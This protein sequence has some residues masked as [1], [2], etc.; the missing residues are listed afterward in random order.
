MIVKL[1]V[2][3]LLLLSS[4]ASPQETETC[5]GVEGGFRLERLSGDCTYE[6]LAEQYE[7]QVFG[8]TGSCVNPDVTA[9][10]DFNMKLGAEGTTPEEIQADA[11]ASGRRRWRRPRRPTTGPRRPSS[12]GTPPRSGSSTGGT[13]PTP[14]SRGRT[15]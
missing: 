3:A 5:S 13:G 8:A 2:P 7:R 9:R 1:S 6:Y 14:A 10:D 12:R 11:A 4:P 15:P